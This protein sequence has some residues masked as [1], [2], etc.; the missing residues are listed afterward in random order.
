VPE[1]YDVTIEKEYKFKDHSII[2]ASF[3]TP[4]AH[5]MPEA[6]PDEVKRCK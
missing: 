4:F 3:I 2:E 6:M 5:H 1:D